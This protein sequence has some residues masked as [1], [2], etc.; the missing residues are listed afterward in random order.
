MFGELITRT[1]KDH[2]WKLINERLVQSAECFILLIGG[3]RHAVK[4]YQNNKLRVCF[5]I[6]WLFNDLCWLNR[7]CQR[8][9]EE[10]RSGRSIV[11]FT[12][13]YVVHKYLCWMEHLALFTLQR[14]SHLQCFGCQFVLVF[15]LLQ[16]LV[17]F[18][19]SGD[20][21]WQ[22]L[23]GVFGLLRFNQ[24]LHHLLHLLLKVRT[25]L[26]SLEPLFILLPHRFDFQLMLPLQPPLLFLQI[27]TFL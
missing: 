15:L 4:C 18:F 20:R 9:L 13:F 21:F 12:F 11:R 22:S 5:G 7:D 27:A 10:V 19:N 8:N 2:T 25:S 14:A 3:P 23:V 1:R 6:A 24:V 16:D 17:P 26:L